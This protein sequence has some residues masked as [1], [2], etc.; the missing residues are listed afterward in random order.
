V[1]TSSMVGVALGAAKLLDEA[2][3]SAEVIDPRRRG[4]STSRR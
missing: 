2:G 3:I 4:R 1:A